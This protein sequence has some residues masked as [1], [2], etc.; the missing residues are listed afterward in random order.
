MEGEVEK[1]KVISLFNKEKN[2]EDRY[3]LSLQIIGEGKYGKVYKAV[4]VDKPDIIF[5]VKVIKL[6]S[7]KV[8]TDCLKEL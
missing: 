4:H 2:K 8:K 7:Q 1:V 5:A 6:T 3:M